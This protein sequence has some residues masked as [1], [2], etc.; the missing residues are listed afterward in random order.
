M[1]VQRAERW[2][3]GEGNHKIAA[4]EQHQQAGDEMLKPRRFA[5]RELNG[6]GVVAR[7]QQ[8]GVQVQALDQRRH[9]VAA[10]VA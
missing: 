4:A 10:A 7:F 8:A 2:A 9:P 5:I 1:V 6:R 3:T